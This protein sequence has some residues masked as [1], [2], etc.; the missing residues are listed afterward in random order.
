M[1]TNGT[2]EFFVPANPDL[3]VILGRMDLEFDNLYFLHFVD[4]KILNFQVPSLKHPWT[5]NADG[6]LPGKADQQLI[7]S[8]WICS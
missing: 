7:L 5:A 4:P 2:L 1:A 8:I 3:V 6:I